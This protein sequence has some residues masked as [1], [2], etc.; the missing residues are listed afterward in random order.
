MQKEE[1]KCLLQITLYPCRN[2]YKSMEKLSELM[3]TLKMAFGY[4][5]SKQNSLFLYISVNS[6]QILIN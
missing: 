5:I 3:P 6:L 4:K 2:P 1:Q